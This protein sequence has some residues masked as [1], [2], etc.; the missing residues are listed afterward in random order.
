MNLKALKYWTKTN[1]A[2]SLGSGNVISTEA[3]DVQVAEADGSIYV[4]GNIE[5]SY[6]IGPYTSTG[7]CFVMRVDTELNLIYVKSFGEKLSIPTTSF[8]TCYSL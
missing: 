4:T 3:T 1:D 5:N 7:N 6:T 8:L 2:Y